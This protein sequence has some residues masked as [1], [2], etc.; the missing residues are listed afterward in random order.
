MAREGLYTAIDLGTSKVCT[1]V[2]SVRPDGSLLVHGMG[3]EPSNGMHKGRV[4]DVE[5]AKASVKQS[6]EKAQQDLA[7]P[8]NWAYVGVSGDHITC[9]N[10]TYVLKRPRNGSGVSAR[11]MEELSLRSMPEV[12]LGKD[13]LHHVPM[14]YVVDGL[15]GVRSPRDLDAET[16]EIRA[17]S[18]MGDAGPLGNVRSSVE[19][20]KVAVRNLVLQPLAA[21]EAV[22]TEDEKEIGTVLIDIG[23]GTSDVAVYRGGNPWYT[24]VLPIGGFQLTRDLSVALGG[25]PFSV[26]EDLKLEY[27]RAMPGGIDD[28]EIPLPAFPGRQQ[29]VISRHMLCQALYER[30]A[31]TLELAMLKLRQAGLREMPPGGLVLT[32][33]SAQLPALEDAAKNLVN[34]PVRIASP[35]VSGLPSDL[36]KPAYSASVGVLLWCIKHQG[37]KRAASDSQRAPNG[38]RGVVGRLLGMASGR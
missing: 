3:I 11:E 38:K 5:K 21:A 20:C 27:G 22:L 26:A 29:P 17:H 30:I 12:P 37:E 4:V 18:I 23:G 32:G 31:E 34:A 13:L 7:R 1:I 35:R 10:T 33:G 8:V 2:A 16:V 24:T 15:S 14:N 28:E 19:G 36:R 25:A 6:I 9:Q